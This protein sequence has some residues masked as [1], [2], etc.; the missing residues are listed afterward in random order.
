V[1]VASQAIS[2]I[3]P[4]LLLDPLQEVRLSF[5]IEGIAYHRAASFPKLIEDSL[6]VVPGPFPF[7]QGLPSYPF[8]T[9]MLLKRLK[10]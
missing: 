6:A 1:P 4:A 8:A 7:L 5:L 10:K 2:G 9:S 3:L